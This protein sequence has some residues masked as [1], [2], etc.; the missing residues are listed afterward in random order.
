MLVW[1]LLIRK[2]QGSA[3][4][5]DTIAAYVVYLHRCPHQQLSVL[6]LGACTALEWSANEFPSTDYCAPVNAQYRLPSRSDE[7]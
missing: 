7:L 1:L 5:G 2:V 4:C 6:E 3:S